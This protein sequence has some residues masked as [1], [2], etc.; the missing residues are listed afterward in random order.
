MLFGLLPYAIDLDYACFAFLRK[1]RFFL[2]RKPNANE[3]DANYCCLHGHAGFSSLAADE[4]YFSRSGNDSTGDGSISTPWKTVGKLNSLDLEPGDVAH[5]ERG[6]VW[7]DGE[8]LLLEEEDP[9]DSSD[10]VTITDYGDATNDPPRI[11]NNTFLSNFGGSEYL[12]SIKIEK[13]GGDLFDVKN[14]SILHNYFY[15]VARAIAGGDFVSGVTIDYNYYSE[16]ATDIVFDG[17]TYH[18]IAAWQSC[19]STPTRD[20]HG[21]VAD[22][23]FCSDPPYLPDEDCCGMDPNPLAGLGTSIAELGDDFYGAPH[24]DPPVVGAAESGECDE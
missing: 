22:S 9:G 12:D 6:G 14:V 3:P 19:G 20:C 16:D 2:E 21:G 1:W 18:S 13:I 8:Q 11:F 10:R 23:H 15:K 7:D 24:A 5:F 4:Y 17:T